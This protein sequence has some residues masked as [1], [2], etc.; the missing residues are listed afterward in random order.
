[1]WI[2]FLAA[3]GYSIYPQHAVCYLLAEWN[4][5]SGIRCLRSLPF[6]LFER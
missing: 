4:K 1:M 6:P 3:S 5:N 2:G